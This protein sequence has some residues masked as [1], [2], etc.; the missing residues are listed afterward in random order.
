MGKNI[1]K[2]LR[3]FL[4]FGGAYFIFDGLLHFFNI[5]ISSANSAWPQ[6][7]ISYAGLLNSIYAS[8]IFL[9]AAIA[10]VIQKDLKKYKAVL[11]VSSVWAIIH[12]S[13][14]LFL[15]WTQ[16]YQQIFKDLPSLLVWLPFYNQLVLIEGGV[17]IIYS[18]IV[19]LWARSK[20]GE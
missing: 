15:V 2:I 13:V 19:Y 18:G 9:A 17:L 6:S 10:F 16:N 12:G 14:L 1:E 3:G 11:V 4:I 8:F 5:K 20:A 7:A